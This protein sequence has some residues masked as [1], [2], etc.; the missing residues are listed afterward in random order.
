[1]AS[2]LAGAFKVYNKMNLINK[3]L[4]KTELEYIISMDSISKNTYEIVD[5]CYR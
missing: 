4:M 1:M 3:K 5:K 2:S